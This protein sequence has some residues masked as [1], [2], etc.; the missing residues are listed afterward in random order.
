MIVGANERLEKLLVG[1]HDAESNIDAGD[2]LDCVME[3]VTV[4]DC[5]FVPVEILPD[6]MNETDVEEGGLLDELSMFRKMVITNKNDESFYCAFT[7]EKEMN[8]RSKEGTHISVKY[9]A[10]AMLR[11]LLETDDE[12]KG[13]VINPWTES[14]VIRK[15]NAEMILQLA[16]KV[17]ESVA[18]SFKSYR[19]EPKAVIDTNEILE[20]W[21]EG[22]HDEDGKKE[23]WE[24][25][26]YPIMPNGH[27]L[28]LF[29]MKGKIYGGRVPDL[30][31]IHSITFFRVLELGVEN[32]KAEILNKYRFKS[33]DAH[34]G[35]VFLHDEV[36]RAAISVDGSEKYD[37]VQM[38]P[39]DDDRQF[40][41]YRNV[42]TAVMDSKGNIAVAYCKNLRD[43]ARYPVMVYNSNGD[44]T[45]QYH[46]EQTLACL[47]V[48]LDSKER[49]WF[50]LHPSETLDMLEQDT[51][52]VET[53]KV[54]L[55]GF[56][57]FALS[58][59]GSKLYTAFTEY[60][61][62]S[63]HFVMTADQNGDYINPIRFEFLPE[64]K[65]GSIL[66][67]KDCTVFG[68]PSTMKSW[69]LLNADGVLYLY[70]IDDC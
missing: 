50:H 12:I 19:L 61:S 59:D 2:V 13:V 25:V 1:F 69:V 9:K 18:A 37:V 10:R 15:D 53:H 40:T 51:K 57:A 45:A 48:N 32:G 68:Q 31:E 22:W 8:A 29:K 66:E 16:D 70:D 55:Q 30:K 34:V 3:S 46:D 36:L 60:E 27:I 67:M 47:D 63:S 17:P 64:G 42:E 56:R 21:R 54:A 41:I 52:R 33:Q 38:L 24:L 44:V 49:V 26:T 35:T 11:D 20:A 14:F 23:P 4:E 43:P 28:L 7:S 62:G 65:D 5:W 6:G 58:T 39:V